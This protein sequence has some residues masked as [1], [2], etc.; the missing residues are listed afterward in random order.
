MALLSVKNL[1]ISFKGGDAYTP[2][3]RD[4]S[5]KLNAGETLALVGESGSG[6]SVTALSL[7]GL[8]PKSATISGDI[9]YQESLLTQMTDAELQKVRGKQIAMIFQEPMTALNPLHSIEKQIAEPLITHEGLTLKQAQPRVIELLRRVGFPEAKERL[10]AYPHQLSGG[11][12]QRVMIAMALACTP[13]IL[14]ADEPTTALDVTIQAG[15]IRLLQSL[16]KELHMALIFISHDLGIVRKLGAGNSSYMGVMHKGEMVEFG[17]INGVLNTPQHAYTRYLIVSEPSGRPLPV[18][19]T[20]KTVLSCEGMTVTFGKPRS[21]WNPRGYELKAVD[22]LSLALRE[23]ETMGV[24]GESGSGKSTFAYALLRLLTIPYE[25]SVIFQGEHLDQKTRKQLRPY[26]SKLQI[27]FQDPFSSL[28]PRFSASQIVGEGL[29]VHE[30]HLRAFDYRARVVDALNAVGLGEEH[31]DR[32][33]H[34]FSGG[35]RQR[36]AIAR[37]L[38]L[39]PKV[40]ILDEPTSALDRSIQAEVIDLLQYLQKERRLSYLFISHDLKVVRAMSHRIIVMYQ[41][42]IVEE[43]EANEIFTS[44]QHVYTQNL[45]AAAC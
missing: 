8:L 13:K 3:V 15:I 40:V 26:R 30:P 36:L 29:R 22:N 7:L 32:Y 4:V 39:D 42:K 6:K 25:G 43:G 27:I 18:P 44:P 31:Y 33:P 23:G 35:Q 28:N 38:I 20:A 11:Q 5:F 37:A 41:G 10:T 19:Q 21:F 24:V 2:V 16:Q 17:D 9:R 14:I 12:R 34:E 45:L 1:N